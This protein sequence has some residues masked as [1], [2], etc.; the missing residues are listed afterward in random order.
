ML[1]TIVF[2]ILSALF[3]HLVFKFADVILNS[4]LPVNAIGTLFAFGTFIMFFGWVG[5]LFGLFDRLPG[6]HETPAYGWLYGVILTLFVYAV[7]AATKMLIKAAE[8]R[9]ARSN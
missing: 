1:A 4:S 2:C 9:F 6:S 5:G 8:R 3:A 7:E